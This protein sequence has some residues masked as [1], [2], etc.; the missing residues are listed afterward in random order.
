GDA[1][2]GGA[3]PPRPRPAPAP[4]GGGERAGGTRLAARGAANGRP[5]GGQKRGGCPGR[6][7]TRPTP[8]GGGGG[9]GGCGA[10]RHSAP[11]RGAEVAVAGGTTV[12]VQK[13]LEAVFGDEA[14]RQLATA[15]RDDLIGR[16]RELLLFESA[17]FGDVR[18][19]IA[20]DP[21]LPE[22]LREAAQAVA[23]RRIA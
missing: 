12:A 9:R 14:M 22:R 8:P 15:A 10:P 3:V 19:N 4:A 17:R 16:V 5:P 13:L 23:D 20:L 18:R 11:P 6:R 2:G 21:A 7:G 1:G